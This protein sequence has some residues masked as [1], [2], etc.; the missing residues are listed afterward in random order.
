[1]DLIGLKRLTV[2]KNYS[3]KLESE[4]KESITDLFPS[5]VK[6]NIFVKNSISRTEMSKVHKLHCRR[7]C[8]FKKFDFK[9]K[10]LALF[11]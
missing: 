10:N 9:G 11:R 4:L 8:D 1:M 7:T 2:Q 6:S 3:A 5:F